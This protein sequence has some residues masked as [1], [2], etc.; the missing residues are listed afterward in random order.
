MNSPLYSRTRSKKQH[1]TIM[2]EKEASFISTPRRHKIKS[3]T[4][5]SSKGPKVQIVETPSTEKQVDDIIEILEKEAL[6][7]DSYLDNVEATSFAKDTQELKKE[8]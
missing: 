2:I 6:E 3:P 1:N 4:Q 8:L 5:T 7:K